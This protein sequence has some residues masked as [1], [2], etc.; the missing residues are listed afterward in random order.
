M[1]RPIVH[2]RCALL[3]EQEAHA[4]VGRRDGR[5]RHGQDDQRVGV[6]G[7]GDHGLRAVHDVGVA[8]ALG[9]QGDG[10]EIAAGGR[11]GQGDPAHAPAGGQVGEEAL[12]LLVRAEAP[13][14]PATACELPTTLAGPSTPG[15]PRRRAHS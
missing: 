4:A 5:V 3:D 6:A 11:L 12:P 10:L 8:A 13:E 7:L 14:Q 2:S 1:S 15:Q 9:P